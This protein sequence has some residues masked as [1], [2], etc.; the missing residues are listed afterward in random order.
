MLMSKS[1]GSAN[2]AIF[3]ELAPMQINPQFPLGSLGTLLTNQG[4]FLWVA[5]APTV[6]IISPTLNF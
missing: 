1:I 2:D 6:Q 3:D 5:A 4:I